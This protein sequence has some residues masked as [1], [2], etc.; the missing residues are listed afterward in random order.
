M[1]ILGTV[2]GLAFFLFVRGLPLIAIHEIR[3]LLPMGRKH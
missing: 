3:S 2:L 1:I